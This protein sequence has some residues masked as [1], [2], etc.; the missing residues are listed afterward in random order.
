MLRVIDML[1]A[2]ADR[3]AAFN[4]EPS[5]ERAAEPVTVQSDGIQAGAERSRSPTTMGRRAVRADS[6]E[7]DAHVRRQAG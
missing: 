7:N 6:S 3:E 5:V 2:S 4:P 1:K